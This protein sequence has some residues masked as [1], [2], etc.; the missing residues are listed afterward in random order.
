MGRRN[1]ANTEL[2]HI[3]F[4]LEAWRGFRDLGPIWVALGTAHTDAEMLAKGREMV[5]EAPLILA[6]AQYSA[7]PP[8]PPRYFLFS[9]RLSVY[10]R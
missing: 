1:E 9:C 4:S 3:S 2:P 8:P 7:S 5:A 10:M 6:D